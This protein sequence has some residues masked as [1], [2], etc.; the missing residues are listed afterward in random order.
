MSVISSVIQLHQP[1]PDLG[2]TPSLEDKLQ[3]L[4][5]L[6]DKAL[7]LTP[8]EAIKDE[9]VQVKEHIFSALSKLE[10]ALKPA[11][12]TVTRTDTPVDSP[13]VDLPAIDPPDVDPPAADLPV[14]DSLV[15][16]P[17]ATVGSTIDTSADPL[18]TDLTNYC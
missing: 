8:E 13:A 14:V 10:L 1:L 17:A 6:D 15:T 5:K 12:V 7:V 18:H 2:T 16:I 9:I 11:S 3:S 4:N